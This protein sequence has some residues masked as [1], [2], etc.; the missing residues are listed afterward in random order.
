VLAA[1]ALSATLTATPALPQQPIVVDVRQGT[2]MS[3]A[4][5]PDASRIVV[6]LL[7]QL[8]EL[9]ITGGAAT[10]LT[11]TDEAA[12]Q[13]RFSPDSRLIAYERVIDGQS[14]VWLFDRLTG[15]RRALTSEPDDDREPDFLPGGDAVVFASNRDGHYGLWVQ[16]L[17]STLAQPLVLESGDAR[18]PAVSERGDIAYVS[19]DSDG[20][21]ML[22][23]FSG[24][25]SRV[26]VATDLRIDAPS[27]RPGGGVIV[28]HTT[29]DATSSSLNMIIL[30]TQPIVRVLT[31]NED[32]FAGRA[33]WLSPT[34]YLYAA[35]GQIWRRSLGGFSRKPVHLFA[36]VS[37]EPAESQ[38]YH[39]DSADESPQSAHGLAGAAASLDGRSVVFAALGDIWL[40]AGGRLS[41]L[42]DDEAWDF[43]PTIAGD[44]SFV[45]YATVRDGRSVLRRVATREGL[46]EPLLA[47][48]GDVF[49]PALDA[50]GTRLAYLA[51]AEPGPDAPAALHVLYL[52]DGTRVD[53]N[54][55]LRA[56]AQPAWLEDDADAALAVLTADDAG[57]ER[58]VFDAALR[59][60]RREPGQRASQPQPTVWPGW[61]PAPPLADNF[62]V[63]AGRLFD[64]LGGDYRR[65]VDI[66]IENRRIK[67]IVGRGVLPLPATVIDAREST[68]L[69]GFIDA[70]VHDT[71]R[72]GV[73]LGRSF[74]AY[75]V[76]TTRMLGRDTRAALARA[77]T[78]ASGRSPGPRV[79][80][81]ADVA[82]GTP[83][84]P[85]QYPIVVANA[86]SV[87]DDPLRGIGS[88]AAGLPREL[89][90]MLAFANGDSALPA[91][92]QRRYSPLLG[93]YQD[94]LGTIVASGYVEITGLAA[95][96]PSAVDRVLASPPD[97]RR[98]YEQLVPATM[99]AAWRSATDS[100]RALAARQEALARLIRGGARIAVGSEAPL[101]PPGVGYVAEL[102][103]LAAAGIPNDQVLRL[104]TAGGALALGVDRDLGTLEPGKLAD[105]VIVDGDPLARLGD[106][107]RVRGAL[108]GGRWLERATLAGDAD[109][110]P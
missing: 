19:T 94:V 15:E 54:T 62:V 77:E 44:G 4:V 84:A 108:V 66:H 43:E 106:L 104:A 63:Q 14:D 31:R 49:A 53:G 89:T 35:D 81:A 2:D 56:L 90:R 12:R 20:R 24:G 70:H 78:W 93:Q 95:L 34:E 46:S 82:E 18:Y 87:L 73:W 5:A 1:A 8:W 103:L 74:L 83:V 100:P 68:V 96:T 25:T 79:I 61:A 57:L 67:A 85:S 55:P 30:S 21:H 75:G 11:P 23:A 33:S 101:V 39:V 107:T 86:H 22:K 10:P 42:T 9:P 72:A 64:G 36:A 6:D 97:A 45:V 17:S 99:V 51:T 7:G 47:G 40:D 27:W 52:D 110:R 80:V 32:A 65:H 69:P 29:D 13:P 48:S 28:Y 91:T 92:M 71:S 102:E 59:P 26:L 105:L 16:S 3:V 58:I 76:T 41:Q 38:G 60:V 109:R 50:S 88:A 98:R 37:I